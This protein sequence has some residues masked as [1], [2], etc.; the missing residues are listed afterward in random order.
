MGGNNLKLHSCLSFCRTL[1]TLKLVDLRIEVVPP[2]FRLLS[3]KSLHLLSVKFSGDESAERL[4][5]SCP[6]LENLVVNKKE[7]DNVMIFNI[8]VP[9]LRSL[10]IDNSEGR[11]RVKGADIHGFVIKAPS[12][13][14]LNVKDTFSNFLMFEHMPE[15]IKANIEVTCDQ[16]EKFIGSLTSIQH[17][18]LCS[19]TSQTPYHRG[20]F[21]FYLEHLEL[22]TCSAGWWNLLNH[23]LED[24]P[25]LQSLKL[26][27][28][29][30][31][32]AS[33]KM[34][35]INDLPDELLVEI[36]SSLPMFKET[37]PTF[38]IS[39][40]WRELWKLVP[41]LKFD[42]KSFDS[43]DSFVS[44]VHT[45]LVLK[46]QVLQTLHLTLSRNYFASIIN[47]LVQ[48]A[49]DRSVRVVRFDCVGPSGKTLR[50]PS[51]LSTCR[52]LEKLI[53]CELSMEGLHHSFRLPSLKTLHLLSVK[54]SGDKSAAS[55]LEICPVLEDLFVHQ[56]KVFS[57]NK[58]TLSSGGTLK[59]LI[60]SEL[61]IDIVP[62]W[63]RLPLLKALHLLSVK[64][65]AEKTVA[66]LLQICPV[67]KDLLVHQTKVFNIDVL[68]LST[69]GTL[70]T[71]R[72]RELS[73]AVFPHWFYMPSLKTLHLLLVKF[74]AD[75]SVASLLQICPVLERLVVDQT[76][77]EVFSINVPILS[78]CGTLKTLILRE[79]SI[80]A[81][82]QWFCLPSLN[83]L[84]LL[85]VKLLGCVS[86]A[87][88]L[89]ICPVL[90]CL[91]VNET[92]EDNV[93]ISN[94][95]VPTLRSLSIKRLSIDNPNET[96]GKRTYIP[97]SH[98]FV[99]KAPSLTDLNFE[100]TI[101]NFLVFESMPEV[102]KANI[103]VICDQSE[104]FIGSL[105]S[106]RHLSLC[107]LTSMTPYPK[108]TSFSSL[109]HLELCTCSSGWANLLVRM[110]N[111]APKVRSLKLKSKHSVNYNEQ[112]N[113]W[114]KPKV[115]PKCLSE[116]LEVLEWRQYEGTEQ[117]S[118]VAEYILANATCLKTATFS[119]R[120]RNRKHHRMLKKLKPMGR[121]SKTCQLV[122]D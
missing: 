93:M 85:S 86:V 122:F 99:I 10:S 53:L 91:V 51:C 72:L 62:S 60:L 48:A 3:L 81:V 34:E 32:P 14:Y 106:I 20:S 76:N 37:V 88:L 55:L 4:L 23:I 94:I 25:R 98:G 64:F 77:T 101:S 58:L 113:L 74:S 44:F 105:T 26:I 12:L 43:C 80:E 73:I 8:S 31:S 89:K 6:V 41:D 54:F 109:R 87:S 97:E 28:S 11:K 67:L 18:S 38:L 36:L 57:I 118:S 116:H 40:R 27:K 47:F 29:F 117:E 39:K 66:S 17:L 13:M 96:H 45:S 114:K 52:T 35:S 121:V 33:P 70:K 78:T 16:S 65:S 83:T 7:V 104:N 19:R 95:D 61:R 84:H 68:T 63:F 103:E 102:I 79:L 50:L 15:V 56:T 75:K 82:P 120:C 22:C 46:N 42:D 71:L 92:K 49:V 100:D 9:T 1:K 112:M 69:W 5:S 24:A 119:T 110:L 115:V 111:D 107:S 108:G 90:E 21:F 2:G 59:T 30:S